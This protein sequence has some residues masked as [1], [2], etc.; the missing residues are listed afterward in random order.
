MS[1]R[2]VLRHLTTKLN[3]NRIPSLATP[4][5]TADFRGI[6][7]PPHPTPSLLTLLSLSLTPVHASLGRTRCSRIPTRT[8][9]RVLA[10]P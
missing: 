4:P 6:H 8:Q 10:R 5:F 3:K 7:S 1:T 2:T 9:R